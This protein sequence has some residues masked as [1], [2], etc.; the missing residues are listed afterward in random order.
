M[1]LVRV[2]V[3]REDG[4]S[5]KESII[6]CHPAERVTWRRG[7]CGPAEHLAELLPGEFGV[8]QLI[9]WKVRCHPAELLPGEFEFGVTQLNYC[10]ESSVSRG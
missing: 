3:S 1:C 7:L 6:A 5:G 2:T 8:T 10:L 9:A 4:P